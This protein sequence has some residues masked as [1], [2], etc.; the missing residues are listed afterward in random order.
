MKT[1]KLAA[2]IMLSAVLTLLMVGIVSAAPGQTKTVTVTHPATRSAIA[3]SMD[4]SDT[5]DISDT[6]GVSDTHDL[7]DTESLSETHGMTQPVA[8]AISIFFSGTYSDVVALHD[9]GFG[10]GE[11][12]RAYFIAELSMGG[13]TPQEILDAVASGMGWGEIMKQYAFK[14]GRGHNLGAIMSGHDSTSNQ[15]ANQN[16]NQ[17]SNPGG[18][19]NCPGNSCTAPGQQNGHGQGQNKGKGNH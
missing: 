16:G 12:A 2:V 3:S 15:N 9:A 6:E 13:A 8:L 14:P 17:N 1:T 11:I 5:T 10:F 18:K 7:S 4:I 19:P